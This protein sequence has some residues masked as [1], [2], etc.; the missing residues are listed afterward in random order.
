MKKRLLEWGRPSLMARK[1]DRGTKDDNVVRFDFRN[2]LRKQHDTRRR[3]EWMLGLPPTSESLGASSD[4]AVEVRPDIGQFNASIP[5]ANTIENAATLRFE[6]L[7]RAFS[8]CGFRK[9]P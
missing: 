9:G 8:Q 5:P 4:E 3:K 7:V 1:E 6:A 2:K